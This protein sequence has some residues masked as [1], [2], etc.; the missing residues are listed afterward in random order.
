[1][2]GY[3]RPVKQWNNGK[4]A[5]FERRKTF[6]INT[7]PDEIDVAPDSGNTSGTEE[8]IVNS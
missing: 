3:L 6:Q 5:E 7:S 4:Q 8:Q 1:V 2:V